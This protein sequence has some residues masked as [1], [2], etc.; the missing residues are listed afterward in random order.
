MSRCAGNKT[1]SLA[2]RLSY[3]LALACAAAGAIVVLSGCGSA[4]SSAG[5]PQA[6][7]S[8]SVAPQAAALRAAL[9]RLD[10][11]VVRRT[12]AFPQNHVRFSFPALTTVRDAAQV[13]GVAQ[14]LLDLP[15]M[16]Q[17]TNPGGPV[18]LGIVYHLT[19]FGAGR[20]LPVISVAVTGMERVDG[21][22]AAR[23]AAVS[24][25]FWTTFAGALGLTTPGY[26]TLR[27]SLPGT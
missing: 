15:A 1:V 10:R 18:D 2:Y 21:L 12:D 8:G 5:A 13:R 4:V 20:A 14:A 25:H 3:G 24:P 9:P 16:S 6:S 17:S 19:F 22:G 11:L 27:G 26:A 7:P 23:W